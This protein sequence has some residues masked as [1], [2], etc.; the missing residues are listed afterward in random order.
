MRISID[1]GIKDQK[2]IMKA[3]SVMASYEEGL[4]HAKKLICNGCLVLPVG[5]RYR[6]VKFPNKDVFTLYSHEKYNRMC[7]RGL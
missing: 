4:I 2:V 7:V 1:K 5:L 6:L 3:V